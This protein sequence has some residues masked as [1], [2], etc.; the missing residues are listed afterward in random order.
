MKRTFLAFFLFL[1]STLPALAETRAMWVTRWDYTT[2]DDVKIIIDNAVSAGINM[3]FFQI[4]G[5]GTVFYP[6]EREVWSE[7]FNYTDPGWDPQWIMAI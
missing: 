2:P 6:S 1:V 5:N 4:R 3:I 7:K